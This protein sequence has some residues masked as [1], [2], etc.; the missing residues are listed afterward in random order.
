MN[1]IVKAL[2]ASAILALTLAAT[3]SY[4]A[5][6]LKLTLQL[7]LKH[8]LG[9]NVINFKNEVERESGG[10]L[11]IE[12]YPSAQLYKDKEVPV[13]VASGAIEMG[14]ASITRFVG[15]VPAVDAFYVPFLFDSEEKVRKATAPGSTIRALIDPAVEATGAKILWYQAFGGA[16]LLTKGDNPIVVP[17]DAKGRK[18]RSFGATISDTIKSVGAAPTIMSGSKQFL[19]YQNGTVD[20]GMTGITAVAS[21]KLYEVMDH[22]TVTYHADIEFVVVIN[23]D[24][25]NGLSAKNQA[26][27][28]KAG[29]RVEKELRDAIAQKEAAARAEVEGKINIIDLTDAQRD[30]WRKATKPVVNSYIKRAGDLGQKIVDAAQKL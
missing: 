8:H 13:A 15:S 1:K 14:V 17:A 5:T 20:A 2:S 22:M 27:I 10:D 25:W 26:I 18:I 29:L 19:A 3:P 23:K 6:T 12:L 30:E 24:V 11:K 21:R 16:I 7:P 4:A 28:S 9:K